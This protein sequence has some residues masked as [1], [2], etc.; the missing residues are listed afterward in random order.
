MEQEVKREDTVYTFSGT[1]R[2]A[3]EWQETFAKKGEYLIS[4]WAMRAISGSEYDAKHRF[5]RGKK[6][7]VR[8][9]FM[10]D[11]T[12]A[13]HRRIEEMNKLASHLCGKKASVGLKAELA[14]LL[15]EYF[16]NDDLRE[17]NITRII[18]PHRPLYTYGSEL[19]LLRVDGFDRGA[20]IGTE[21]VEPGLI[22]DEL[23]A[24]AYLV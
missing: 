19:C 20:N 14:F 15:R 11:I 2:L 4:D 21:N 12:D 5:A 8:L 18:V 13:S 9:L 23:A 16:T 22:W 3:S 1:G 6:Y 24:F 7:K 10:R 17:L